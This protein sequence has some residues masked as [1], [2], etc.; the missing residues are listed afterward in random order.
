MLSTIRAYFAARRAAAARLEQ[1]RLCHD[2][3]LS[4]S[5]FAKL[6]SMDSARRALRLALS[7]AN[8]GRLACKADIFRA[9]NA[10]RAVR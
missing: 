2:C 4:A 3:L 9:L 1:V 7:A 10:T 6:G 5:T 8:R